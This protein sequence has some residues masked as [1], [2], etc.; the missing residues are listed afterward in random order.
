MKTITIETKEKQYLVHIGVNA[1]K[2]A[3]PQ[4]KEQLVNADQIVVIAD[5][6]VAELH[7]N[8][9]LLPLQ[10]IVKNN[11]HV[12]T[13]PAGES[14]KTMESFFECHSFL[15]QKGCTR[16]SV[17]FAFGGGACGDL[18]GFVA[19]SFMRGIPFYQCP[20]TILAHDSAVGG[21]T[22]INHPLGKNMIGS[23][24]QPE[25]V[26][27]DVSLL[28]TLPLH[29]VRSGMAEVIKHALISDEFWLDELLSIT[30]F[31]QLSQQDL[32][33]HLLKGLQVK[34]DIIKQ[35]EF[36]HS[37]RK[38]LNLGH[39]YGHAI[40][41][42]TGFG[43]ITHGESVAI[44]LVYALILSEEYGNL[45]SGFAKKYFNHM[46]QLG[47]SFEHVLHHT[48]DDLHNLM[49]RDKKA[50]YGDIHFVL[51]NKVG[52]PFLKVIPKEDAQR[53][54]QQLRKWIKGVHQ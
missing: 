16:K 30:S 51:L 24:Y 14:C 28:T 54:D 38:Y 29:E 52:E 45:A 2:E 36:E 7:L 53:A 4:Y 34:A 22:A 31:S 37:V 32:L 21:K 42:S 33:K 19:S 39:T 41:T 23:F 48:F 13:V 17:L 3:I 1:F 40:E 5:G 43:Q 47:F 20:T 25:A 11:I 50:S 46:I 27:F 6:K 9:L 26:I 15:L 18:A 8:Q 44:G 49:K 35:D 10:T 12:H